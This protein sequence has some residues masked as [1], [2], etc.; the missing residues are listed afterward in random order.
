MPYKH[1]T[2]SYRD[3][4]AWV[5]WCDAFSVEHAKRVAATLR[6]SGYACKRER[7][8]VFVRPADMAKIPAYLCLPSF[9]VAIGATSG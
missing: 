1:Q 6:S 9:T 2:E 4:G 3:G 7:D 8:R 5:C